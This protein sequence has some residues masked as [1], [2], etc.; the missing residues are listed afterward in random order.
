MKKN[1]NLLI[2]D[3]DKILLQSFKLWLNE[4]GYTVYTAENRAQA[5]NIIKNK[6]ISVILL[7]YRLL[8]ENGIDLAKKILELKKDIKIIMI[9]GYPSYENAVE[10]IKA[11]IFDYISKSDTNEKILSTIEKAI[12]KQREESKNDNN[13]INISI[14]L[15]CHHSFLKRMLLEIN[16]NKYNFNLIEN[17]KSFRD[18]KGERKVFNPDIVLICATCN[19]ENF[20]S[21]INTMP[22]I[23]NT[24][25]DSKLMIINNYFN[26]KEQSKLLSFGIKG[27]LTIDAD[28]ND[29]SKGIEAVY[30][31]DLWVSRRVINL[32][33]KDT[34]SFDLNI[35]KEMSQLNPYNLTNREFEILRH[36]INGYKN[37]DIGNKLYISEK[38]VKVHVNKIYKKLGVN[39]RTSAVKKVIQEK[40]I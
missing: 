38:T 27:F 35:S 31:N 8:T 15:L 33:F 21:A 26:D 12:Q 2:I 19:F 17:F 4:K 3:D 23:K 28:I 6:D 13:K 29:F 30:N 36:L 20:E 37:K 39:N 32:Y 34:D 9:T 1:E 40:L 10:S 7:D 24:Y 22:F 14:S 16:N 25:P 11:G 18:I 5:I